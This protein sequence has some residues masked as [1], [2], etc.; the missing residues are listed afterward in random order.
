M[1]N[2]RNIRMKLVFSEERKPYLLDISSLLYDFEL[3][4][5]YSLLICAEEYSEYKF[6]QRFW[7]RN[8]RPLRL[9][10][11]LRAA[12]IIKDSPLTVELIIAGVVAS[13]GA[14]WTLAQII[15][16]ITNWR[17]NRKK[18]K[19]EIEKLERELGK[20]RLEEEKAGLDLEQKMLKRRAFGIQ[21]VIVRRFESNP[22]T[23]E[24]VELSVEKKESDW[25][26][27]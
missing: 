12:K 4:H 2:I 17:L 19:L 20:A 21:C 26:T 18:L 24:S 1:N 9:S 6:S 10:H 22:I 8:G 13:S 14:L 23:L 15:G 25:E 3:L 5:D 27:K 11:R 16:K 7:Y